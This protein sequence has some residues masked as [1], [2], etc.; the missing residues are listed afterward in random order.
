MRG[1]FTKF[2]LH[3]AEPLHCADTTVPQRH[4]PES[5]ALTKMRWSQGTHVALECV[6]VAHSSVSPLIPLFSQCKAM[7][8]SRA[9]SLT[10]A[11]LAFGEL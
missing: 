3:H 11:W 1:F 5:I 2:A 8:Y 4:R 7:N 6:N 10:M 9:V